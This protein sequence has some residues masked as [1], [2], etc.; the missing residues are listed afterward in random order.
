MQLYRES[1][2]EAYHGPL[3]ELSKTHASVNTLMSTLLQ[4]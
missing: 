3:K 2:A 1:K 4:V